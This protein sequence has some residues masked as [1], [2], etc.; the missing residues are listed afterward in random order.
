MLSDEKLKNVIKEL[1]LWIKQ[2][3]NESGAKGMAQQQ[4]KHFHFR[5]A[6]VASAITAALSFPPL[7]PITMPF[8]PDSF[9]YCLLRMKYILI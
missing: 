6:F 8:A 1:E 3:V 7:F 9:T 5:I 2:Y 4:L